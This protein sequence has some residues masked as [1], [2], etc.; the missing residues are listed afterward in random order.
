MKE[1]AAGPVSDH[2][3]QSD[4]RDGVLHTGQCHGG[5]YWL[6]RNSATKEHAVA[7]EWDRIHHAAADV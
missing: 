7:E 3:S 2:I 4:H 5:T 6:I 1:D